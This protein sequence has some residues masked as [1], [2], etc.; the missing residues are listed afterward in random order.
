LND[1]KIT[2]IT[3]KK[4]IKFDYEDSITIQLET[5]YEKNNEYFQLEERYKNHK[6]IVI[7]LILKEIIYPKSYI[8][9][10]IKNGF[11]T[12]EEICRFLF[13]NYLGIDDLHKR[14]L[15][16]LTRDI[17]E[18]LGLLDKIKFAVIKSVQ[19]ETL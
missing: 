12:E 4:D 13:S 6:D 17:C 19:S 5:K 3:A 9:E 10:L 18:E 14:P 7:E 1:L 8:E 11:G 2:E 15:S 16:K